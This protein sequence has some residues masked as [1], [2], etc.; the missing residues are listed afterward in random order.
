MILFPSLCFICLTLSYLPIPLVF[1]LLQRRLGGS[2]FSSCL[3]R[4]T[5][6]CHRVHSA[7][8]ACHEHPKSSSHTS[9]NSRNS[10][11]ICSIGLWRRKE[12]RIC[13]I[14]AN[15]LQLLL[16]ENLWHWSRC[17]FAKEKERTFQRSNAAPFAQSGTFG[18]SS[19]LCFAQSCHEGLL[20]H[21]SSRSHSASA[22]WPHGAVQTGRCRVYVF[23]AQGDVPQ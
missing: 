4:C 6:R 21:I 13:S 19:E 17:W 1:E 14:M 15:G 3:Q 22:E 5:G 2:E 10:Q 9:R 23:Q 18:S 12:K 7:G 11:R 20:S 8:Y 16:I